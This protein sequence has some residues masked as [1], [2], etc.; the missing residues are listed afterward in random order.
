MGKAVWLGYSETVQDPQT[1]ERGI[2]VSGPICLPGS[3]SRG[4]A[5]LL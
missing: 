3:Q 5:G 2:F 4:L 1:A